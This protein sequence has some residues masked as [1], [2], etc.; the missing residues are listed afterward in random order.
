MEQSQLPAHAELA[1]I[2]EQDPDIDEV[3]NEG[4]GYRGVSVIVKDIERVWVI[5]VG[6]P[7]SSQIPVP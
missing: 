6:V 4:W 7:S 1:A 3:Q 5:V 2:F